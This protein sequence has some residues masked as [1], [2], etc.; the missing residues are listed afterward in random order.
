MLRARIKIF[1]VKNIFEHRY[2]YRVE[3]LRFSAT[4]AER[5]TSESTVEERAIR[6]IADVTESTSGA[7][8]LCD[9]ASKLVLASTWQ[10]P[11]PDLSGT[12]YR[13]DPRWLE[14]VAQ[15][16]WVLCFDDIRANEATNSEERGLPSWLYEDP[17]TWVGI[18]LVRAERLVGF[19]IL[20][21]PLI[22]RALDWEDFDLL[23]VIAKQVA[24]HLTDAQSQAELEEGRRFDEFNRRFAFIIHD[25][26][27]VVSQLSLVSSN[28]AEH[29]ANPKFQ[30]AMAK[31]IEN[32]TSKMTSMLS[33]LSPARVLDGPNLHPIVPADILMKLASVYGS[34][35]AIEI[36]ADQDCLILADAEQLYEA[37]GHLISNAID[38]SEPSSPVGLS[39]E[40]ID[41]IVL[42]SIEDNGCGMTPE[43]IQNRLFRS[44]VSTKEN[45]FGIGAA[46]ARS[47]VLAMGGDMEV[48]SIKDEGTRFI[49]SFPLIDHSDENGILH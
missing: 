9:R 40:I 43:F 18:P 33:R 6:S 29:G 44:F 10:R 19:V 46:E 12:S 16:G 15:S 49:V 17:Q 3:W 27:N 39:L 23:K 26:K 34:Q 47:L 41:R 42:I 5:A 8:I 7:L 37:L 24:V 21:R 2:D 11:A 28:A 48:F 36:A 13:A 20:D 31:T 45:G 14:S 38:A 30:A 1:I 4:I 32:A 22:E 35:H 25:L